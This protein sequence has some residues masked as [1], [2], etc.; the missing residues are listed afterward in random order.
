MSLGTLFVFKPGENNA[1]D[2][3]I[4]ELLN[5]VVRYLIMPQ[6]IIWY[7]ITMDIYTKGLFA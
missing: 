6:P 1:R 7:A 5:K 4:P 3:T 2:Q